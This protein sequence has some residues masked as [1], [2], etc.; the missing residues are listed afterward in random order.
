M[1]S[2][3]QLNL[4]STKSAQILRVWTSLGQVQ[5]WKKEGKISLSTYMLALE[6]VKNIEN[7]LS[8]PLLWL[9]LLLNVLVYHSTLI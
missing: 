7:Y 6:K 8:L 2:A 5:D 4:K 9:N 1:A 3:L